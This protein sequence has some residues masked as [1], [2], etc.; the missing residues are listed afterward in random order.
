VQGS[1]GVAAAAGVGLSV[2]GASRAASAARRVPGSRVM[3][4][5]VGGKG[6]KPWSGKAR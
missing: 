6:N 1:G 5:A 3:S 4:A 2:A